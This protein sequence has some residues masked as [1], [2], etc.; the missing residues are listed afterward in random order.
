MRT[1]MANL[2][3]KCLHKH[4][5]QFKMSV[6]KLAQD[7]FFIVKPPCPQV[8]KYL[9]FQQPWGTGHFWEWI[10][11]VIKASPFGCSKM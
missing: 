2:P 11:S 10:L 9:L 6:G 5:C 3:G 1:E 8:A 4:H 7:F